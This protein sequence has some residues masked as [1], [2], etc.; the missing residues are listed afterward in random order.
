MKLTALDNVLLVEQHMVRSKQL[1][2]E[3]CDGLTSQQ[4]YIVEGIYN[5]FVPLI[6]ATLTA[7]QVKQ[8]FGELEKQSVAGGQ[9]RT[10]AGATVDVARKANQ[11]IDNMGKWLQNTTPVQNFDAKFEKLK[12]DINKKFPDSKLLDGVSNLAMWVQENPGKSAAVIGVLTALASLAAGPVG[13]AIAGQV[14]RGASELLKGEKLSTAIGKG[15]KTAALGYLSGKFFDML[16]D[17]FAGMRESA[18]PVPGAEESGLANV[19]WGATNKI[20]APGMEWTRTTQG[21]NVAVFPQEQEAIRQAM[22]GIQ[23]GDAGSFDALYT[24]AKEVNSKAYKSAINDIMA[25]ARSAQL[26]NDSMLT[27]INGL[28]DAARATAQGAVAASGEKPAKQESFYVQTRPLSEG[29]VY[30]VFKR[31]LSEA[32]FMDKAKELGGKAAGALAKGAE[33]AGKQ[34]T[35]KVTSAKLNAAWRLEGSPLDSEALKQFLLNYGDIDAAVIDQIYADMKISTGP[36]YEEVEKL[37]SALNTEEKQEM[38][39]FLN[40]QLG[41]A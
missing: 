15:V 1:L 5:E 2:R 34:A 25:G 23:N 24:I 8:I 38:I 14:L 4:R 10:V 20:T 37:I 33:W 18:L 30:M 21:F 28:K 39:T 7:D 13:G 6:E 29:Q 22:I 31:V 17:W 3:S 27:W 32:G 9:N 41:T 12:A 36:S 11:V 40:T 26:D 35:E 19:S 16:G